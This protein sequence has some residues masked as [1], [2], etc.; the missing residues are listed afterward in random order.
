[1]LLLMSKCEPALRDTIRYFKVLSLSFRETRRFVVIRGS[2]CLNL[3]YL[4]VRVFLGSEFFGSEFS[5][6]PEGLSF[7]GLSFRDIQ[8]RVWKTQTLK[9][10]LH[11]RFLSQQLDA[12]SV[13][14]K[15]H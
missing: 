2:R 3:Y 8:G 9:A 10:R 12:I 13:A 11:R 15:S 7:S 14:V 1:M 6:H 5:R 4:R